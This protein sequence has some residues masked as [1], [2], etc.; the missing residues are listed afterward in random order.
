MGKVIASASGRS[1]P[2]ERP[3]CA[4]IAPRAGQGGA[5]GGGRSVTPGSH[6]DR[7]LPVPLLVRSS[8]C[9][10]LRRG[11]DRVERPSCAWIAP[12]AGQG[13]AGGGSGSVTPGSQSDRNLP[14]PLLVRS[15]ER[16][17]PRRGLDR[18][19]LPSCAWIAPR[20]GQGGSAVAVLWRTKLGEVT[21]RV[22]PDLL[23]I[24]TSPRPSLCTRSERSL[25]RRGLDH[26]WLPSASGRSPRIPSGCSRRRCGCIWSMVRSF[27]PPSSRRRSSA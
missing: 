26:G 3:S 1:L 7:N 27:S 12:R 5:G 2:D 10:L 4:W 18:V 17:L 22:R 24:E 25:L 6:S 9:S 19:E 16:S 15:S 23:R 13:G 14:V 8:E 11:L 21:T 20:A